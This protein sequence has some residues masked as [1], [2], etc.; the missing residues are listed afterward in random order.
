VSSVNDE[1]GVNYKKHS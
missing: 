1:I